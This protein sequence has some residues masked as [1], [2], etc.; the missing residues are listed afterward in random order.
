MRILLDL[1]RMLS[2]PPL[3]IVSTDFRSSELPSIGLAM[4]SSTSQRSEAVYYR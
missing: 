2:I 4:L 3:P 1:I